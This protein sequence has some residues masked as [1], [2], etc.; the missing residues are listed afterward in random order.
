HVVSIKNGLHAQDQCGSYQHHRSKRDSGNKVLP[1][2]DLLAMTGREWHQKTRRLSAIRRLL[3]LTLLAVFVFVRSLAAYG[4]SHTNI[5][6]VF[7]ILMENVSWPDIVN[8]TNAPYLTKVLFPQSSCA[9]NMFIVPGTFGSLPQYLWLESGTNWGVTVDSSDPASHHF[10]TTNHFVIQLQNA[11]ISWRAY[12]EGIN[13]TTC[14][15]ASSGL[16]A[17]FHNPFVYFD[18]IYLNA[19]H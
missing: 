17:D 8:S 13:G 4:S 10:A 5:Q 12:Q 15:T 16:Y 7:L 3:Q 18:D 1:H 19:T 6:T 14:P 9:T 2:R 11:G